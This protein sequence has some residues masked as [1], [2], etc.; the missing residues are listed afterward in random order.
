L[1]PLVSI[2]SAAAVIFVCFF[3]YYKKE[4]YGFGLYF[5][6]FGGA[7]DLTSGPQFFPS[8]M[9]KMPVSEDES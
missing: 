5:C 3:F 4:I 1:Y 6:R 8:S 7:E 9:G 2:I